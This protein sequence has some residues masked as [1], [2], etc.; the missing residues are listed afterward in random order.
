[1]FSAKRYFTMLLAVALLFI[2]VLPVTAHADGAQAL[3]I[4]TKY[5]YEGMNKTWGQGYVPTVSGNTVKVVLPLVLNPQAG[6]AAIAGDVVS[7][8]PDYG[9]PAGSPF[10]FSNLETSVK[11]VDHA[12]NG[13]ATLKKAWL[14]SFSFALEKHRL[15]GR[16]PLTFHVNYTLPDGTAAMQD[17]TVYVT[18]RNGIDPNATPKPLPTPKPTPPPQPQPRLIMSQYAVAPESVE[19]GKEFQLNFDITNTSE[20]VN[21]RNIKVTVKSESE[22]FKPVSGSNTLIVSSLAKSATKPLSVKMI[23]QFD[24]VPKQQKVTVTIDYEDGNGTAYSASDE[25]PVQVVQ[26]LHIEFDKPNV[27]ESMNAGDTAPFTLQ[28][29]NKGRSPVYNVMCVLEAPGLLPEAGVFLGS[30]DPGTAKPAQV[31][32]FPGTRNMSVAADGSVTTGGN[33]ADM[34][35]LTSGTITITYEDEFG[36]QYSSTVKIQTTINAP[37][38]PVADIKKPDPPKASQWWVSALIAA[39]LIAA[40]L[41]ILALGRKSRK[42]K[43]QGRE[44]Q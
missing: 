26:P 19:A 27:P 1:M 36:K 30:I 33:D 43:V 42:R 24:A 2:T 10:V 31:M 37:A 34:F 40:I 18:I 5:R 38:E 22:D 41:I 28:V 16:Y 7:V 11:L 6:V 12:V 14:L 15:N 44:E 3:A 8:K 32:V 13:T 23:A 21:V 20:T 35:G 25:I 4:D 17:F 9:D 29:L 39:A